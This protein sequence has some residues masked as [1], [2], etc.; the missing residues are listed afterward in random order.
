MTTQTDQDPTDQKWP[1]PVALG[2]TLARTSHPA[3]GQGRSAPPEAPPGRGVRWH[4]LRGV[5]LIALAPLVF[6]LL[7]PF[8]FIGQEVTA[9]TW[10]KTLVEEQATRVLNGGSLRFGS[11][12]VEL[13][14]DLHPI[15]RMTGTVLADADGFAVAHVPAIAAQ[16]SPRGLLLRREVL[17]QR[18]TLT[19]AQITLRRSKD[20]SVALA[21]EA[22]APAAREAASPAALLAQIAAT[23]DRPVLEAMER[24]RAEGLIVNYDDARAGRAWTVDGGTLELNLDD[25]K[26]HLS[27]AL[28]LLSG[29]AFITTIDLD[30]LS[31]RETGETDVNVA[32]QD[33]LAA[34]IATQSPALSW[35][36]LLDAPLSANLT[37]RIDAGGAVGPLQAA[38]QIGGGALRPTPQ[39]KPVGFDEMQVALSYDPAAGQVGFD[40]LRVV[41]D[42]GT[43]EGD[44]QAYLREITDGWPGALLGQF[45]LHRIAL[46]PAGLYGEPVTLSGANAE[47]RLRLDPF[48]VDIGVLSVTDTDVDGQQS[49]L[50]A[51]G[52]I[53]ASYKG[54]EVSL[55]AGLDRLSMSRLM[56]LWPRSFRP[57]MRQWLEANIPRATLLGTSAGLRIGPQHDGRV[58]ALNLRFEDT[59]AT[60]LQ[61][62]PVLQGVS[63]M[64][65]IQDN[66]L[67]VSLDTGRIPA[68]LGGVADL[69][70][71][72]FVVPDITVD[73]APSIV[74]LRTQSTIKAALSLL[75]LPPFSFLTRAGRPVTLAQGWAEGEGD[76]RLRLGER[77]PGEQP[78]FNVRARLTD[79]RSE[80]L[81]PGRVLAGAELQVVANNTGM[82]V[83]GAMR[84]GRVPGMA[85]WSTVFGPEGGGRS[86]VEGTVELSEQFIDEFGIG[87]PTGAVRGAGQGTFRLDFGP[88]GPP[89][90]GMTS[91]LAGLR[92]SLPA[93]GWGKSE[94]ERGSFSITGQLGDV[95]TVDE[96]QLD[97]AGLQ[98]SGFIRLNSDGGLNRAVFNRVRLGGW[99]DSPAV[100]V[101]R[102][103]GR[104]VEVQL[105]GGTLDLRQADFGGSGGDESGPMQINLDRLQVTE[106]IAL[107]GFQGTFSG[108]GGFQGTFT[109]RVN[110]GASVNGT[111]APGGSG[112]AVRVQSDAAGEVL[113][114]AGFLENA[115][116][117]TLDLSLTPTAGEG[118]Y[119]GTLRMSN[120][121][122][123]DAPAL[124]Q[125][126]DAIS[127]VGL[128]QQLDGQ[129]LSFNQ[130]DAA[131]RIDPDR[132]TVSQSSAV[133]P[134][135]GIS[136]DGVYTQATRQMDF[137]GV[138]S[139]LYLINGV[140]SV[141]TRRGEGLF[142][143]NYTLRGPIGTPQVGV[144]PLSILTPGMFREIFRAQPPVQNQ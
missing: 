77:V 65:A 34:D 71:S 100:L 38:L 42:W 13:G 130:V 72:T 23:F 125:L 84:L 4:A 107:T 32:I 96:V 118:S 134:G 16:L 41:S 67:T 113:A 78:Q 54:L 47:F 126:I 116:G 40:D 24:V 17:P 97:A 19:G 132:I 50:E 98:T 28:A 44:G 131:F 33:A 6:V 120:L 43:I 31:D 123:R 76:I 45:N 112:T 25:E 91:D 59:V 104:P 122:V 119:D 15:V 37:G 64:L 35:L 29:R 90:F 36:G 83:A 129:G 66:S 93:L 1:D 12:T 21:F 95:S 52:R 81:V 49:R 127:V 137:R 80:V 68:P 14:R 69:T 114:S 86:Q 27:G 57:G 30:L 99:L 133:G 105:G 87:L 60:V 92:L 144:N 22:A 140:G 9:P 94:G 139:P 39:A 46:D 141:L 7:T 11:I 111:V 124:A 73:R 8:L 10:I 20:G 48:A 82:S 110:D 63:G 2:S 121:R 109:A 89:V 117:G 128:L 136:I 79:V 53:G 75:D 138:I 5:R 88:D 106:G 115:R 3:I 102:G 70:G 58:W 101:G 62:L 103:G 135:L 18:I 61:S 55:D 51:S 85:T 108:V 26:L 56:V 142:G 74:H 143:F